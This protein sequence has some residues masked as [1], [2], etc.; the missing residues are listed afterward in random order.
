MVGYFSCPGTDVNFWP[1]R[2]LLANT[3]CKEAGNEDSSGGDDDEKEEGEKEDEKEE[4]EASSGTPTGAIAGGVAGGVLGF[5]LLIG[6]SFFYTKRRH[7]QTESDRNE[8]PTTSELGPSLRPSE[9]TASRSLS[10]LSM[11]LPAELYASS[12]H[13][14][15]SPRP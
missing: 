7:R 3:L 8:T 15:S 6:L 10:T 1:R 5:A 2:S 9:L 12:V 14:Q 13:V 4:E 11:Q